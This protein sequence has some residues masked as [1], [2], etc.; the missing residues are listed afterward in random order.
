[1]LMQFGNAKGWMY[2]SGAD[3][4]ALKAQGWVESS[5]EERS[6]IIEEKRKAKA[7]WSV[8]KVPV[9]DDKKSATIAVQQEAVKGKPGRKPKTLGVNS[10]G[11]RPK[12]SKP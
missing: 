9:Q 5:D 1:M 2:A 7:E 12:S 10:D 4:D 11:N 6:A 3:V 8:V